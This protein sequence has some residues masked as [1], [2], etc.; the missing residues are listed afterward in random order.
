MKMKQQL[1][2]LLEDYIGFEVN[3]FDILWIY[4]LEDGRWAVCLKNEIPPDNFDEYL[5]EDL[6]KSIDFFLSKREEMKL[7]YDFEKESE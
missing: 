3:L 5:F 6:E 1:I 7:G 2:N 4:Q